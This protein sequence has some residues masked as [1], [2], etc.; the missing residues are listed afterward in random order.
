MI[1]LNASDVLFTR[2][3]QCELPKNNHKLLQ[4]LKTLQIEFTT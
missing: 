3:S 1:K 2:V 4:W